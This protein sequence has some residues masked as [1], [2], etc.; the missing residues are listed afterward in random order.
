MHQCMVVLRFGNKMKDLI[1]D[2]FAIDANAILALYPYGSMVYGTNHKDSDFDYILVCKDGSIKNDFALEKDRISLHIYD[3]STFIDQLL[4]HKISAL[5]C[6]F[7]PLDRAPNNKKFNFALDIK[8]LRSSISEKSSHSWI[9][10]KKKFEVEKDHNIYIAK[11]S[12]FHSLRIIDFGIQ[13]ATNKRIIDYSSTNSI[14]EEI[15]TNPS[16]D[17]NDYKDNYQKIFNSK[18]TEFRKIAPK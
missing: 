1:I 3:E 15:I 14:W 4:N 8:K 13:I 18:M 10:S 7:L 17:W 5:E 9:K 16:E 11:K 12:L 6:I 2:K